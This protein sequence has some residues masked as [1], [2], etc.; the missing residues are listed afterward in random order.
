MD[1]NVKVLRC[2][3]KGGLKCSVYHGSYDG[4]RA[5]QVVMT[6]DDK[7]SLAQRCSWHLRGDYHSAWSQ[8]VN[9]VNA[10]GNTRPARHCFC[11]QT[12]THID[13]TQ[14]LTAEADS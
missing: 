7:A 13:P 11:S 1:F 12:S 6:A 5:L 4:Y 14:D 10:C 2:H 9:S 8:K 3:L